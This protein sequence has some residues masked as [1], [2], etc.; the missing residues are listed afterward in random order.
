MFNL[1]VAS[2]SDNEFGGKQQKSVRGFR[3]EEILGMIDK[4]CKYEMIGV[5]V[6]D[7]DPAV[8]MEKC[9][10]YLSRLV[11]QLV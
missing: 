2:M 11:V 3:Q 7:Y 6:W 5:F 8:E 4:M 1:S 10:A 9:G